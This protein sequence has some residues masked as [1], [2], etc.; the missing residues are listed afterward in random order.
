VHE[1]WVAGAEGMLAPGAAGH[2][3]C[4]HV[5]TA[6]DAVVKRGSGIACVLAA[7]SRLPFYICFYLVE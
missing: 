7:G 4:L 3:L 5:D 1:G 2:V 6:Q